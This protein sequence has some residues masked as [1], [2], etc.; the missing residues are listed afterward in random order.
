MKRRKEGKEGRKGGWKEMNRKG[1]NIGGQTCATHLWTRLTEKV[2][3]EELRSSVETSEMDNAG[4]RPQRTENP[5]SYLSEAAQSCF[6]LR[7]PYSTSH[8]HH[9]AACLGGLPRPTKPQHQGK[10]IQTDP[11]L[12]VHQS[13]VTS[14]DNKQIF[15]RWVKRQNHL[16]THGP[17]DKRQ[18]LIQKRSTPATGGCL[19]LYIQVRFKTGLQLT[20]CKVIDCI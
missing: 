3:K 13:L 17:E 10:A 18:T 19:S 12:H 15:K 1:D 5:P 20:Q 2:L 8:D 4:K 7:L 16:V 11:T 6:C 9:R 14:R